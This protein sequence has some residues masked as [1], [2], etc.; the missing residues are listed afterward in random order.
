MTNK[1]A[2]FKLIELAKKTDDLAKERWATIDEIKVVAEQFTK[3]DHCDK[4]IDSG[5]SD[6]NFCYLCY[7][8]TCYGCIFGSVNHDEY[9]VACKRCV[10]KAID[11]LSDYLSLGAAQ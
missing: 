1:E 4:E 6:V 7:S 2:H 5:T 10:D 3:C 8:A 11:L 9:T